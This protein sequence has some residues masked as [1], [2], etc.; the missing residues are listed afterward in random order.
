MVTVIPSS[1]RDR[2]WQ[3]NE[4]KLTAKELCWVGKIHLPFIVEEKHVEV[5]IL[6]YSQE[7][8]RLKTILELGVL[9]TMI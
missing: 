9:E 4:K 8:D 6:G 5:Q 7:E 1:L 3:V 2:V